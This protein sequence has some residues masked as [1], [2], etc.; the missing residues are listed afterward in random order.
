MRRVCARC[1]KEFQGR[2]SRA[3]YCSATCRVAANRAKKASSDGVV[4]DLPIPVRGQSLEDAVAAM[5]SGREDDA[6][7]QI[8]ISLARRIDNSAMDS[9]SGVASLARELRSTLTALGP[10]M[11]AAGEQKT[12]GKVAQFRARRAAAAVS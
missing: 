1:A 12:G 11:P 8:A 5:L 4:I 9:A 2:S 6:V 3:T 10:A 7:A